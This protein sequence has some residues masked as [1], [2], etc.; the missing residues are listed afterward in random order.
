M[1]PSNQKRK[2]DASDDEP[3]SKRVP[4]RT[5]LSGNNDD[6]FEELA[7]V[8]D[9]DMPAGRIKVLHP[10]DRI[11]VHWKALF[12]SP[13]QYVEKRNLLN[14]LIED[15]V[16][17]G[18]SPTSLG[19]AERADR[20]DW[21]RS[22]IF[23][24]IKVDPRVGTVVFFHPH[25]LDL[26]STRHSNATGDR[27][28]DLVETVDLFG[29]AVSAMSNPEPVAGGLLHTNVSAEK[30][31]DFVA[32]LV[33]AASSEDALT[34]RV[35]A[36]AT[37][38][39]ATLCRSGSL[40]LKSA[41][42]LLDALAALALHVVFTDTEGADGWTSA[43]HSLF[44]V[45]GPAVDD[46]LAL[47]STQPSESTGLVDLSSTLR[48]I[49]VATTKSPVL[50][51]TDNTVELVS[52]LLGVI[53]KFPG[54]AHRDDLACIY[55]VIADGDFLVGLTEQQANALA[56]LSLPRDDLAVKRGS[57][58]V[59]QAAKVLLTAIRSN[60]NP[61][62]KDGADNLYKN[63]AT[64]LV[65]EMV[66][67]I[68][69]P[70]AQEE[71]DTFAKIYSVCRGRPVEVSALDVATSVIAWISEMDSGR[72]SPSGWTV[73]GSP[74]GWTRGGLA[75]IGAFLGI[76]VRGFDNSHVD[77]ALRA[78]ECF[79]AYVVRVTARPVIGGTP[80]TET[81]IH[82]IEVD[83]I[84]QCGAL[85]PELLLAMFTC[86]LDAAAGVDCFTEMCNAAIRAHNVMTSLIYDASSFP[87][88]EEAYKA[89]LALMLEYRNV[90]PDG[91]SAD[92]AADDARRKHSAIHVITSVS[93][94]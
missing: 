57:E 51:A 58:E 66:G 36:D 64:R 9:H 19:Y 85:V 90:K 23:E 32:R 26:L 73:G 56:D 60:P 6:A 2:A 16:N 88:I 15:W 91:T 34:C 25:G 77:E 39:I 87:K 24:M 61:A 44:C 33:G 83:I 75:V 72:G 86:D 10:K 38:A 3:P 80:A 47:V 82:E 81:A 70:L 54:A 30:V 4:Q 94:Y 40:T 27:L 37:R 68:G 29:H 69:S 52:A 11:I 92:A 93:G 28:K 76:L 1:D 5:A 78:L 55:P 53:A 89:W 20:L 22:A 84:T 21:V 12:L 50:F 67:F 79:L 49:I 74:L 31:S 13:V 46:S 63:R 65:A 42:D 59:W 17:G 7:A 14:L 8:I 48:R 45:L 62:P 71:A 41:I 43:T 18:F 35:V